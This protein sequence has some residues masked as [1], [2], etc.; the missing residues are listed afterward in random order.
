MP[1]PK[2]RGD[3]QSVAIHTVAPA[4]LNAKKCV[5]CALIVIGMEVRLTIEKRSLPLISWVRL[6]SALV[7]SPAALFGRTPPKPIDLPCKLQFFVFCYEAI[8]GCPQSLASPGSYILSRLSW[9]VQTPYQRVCSAQL[10]SS[11]YKR[12]STRIPRSVK[13]SAI[14]Y[15]L[16]N[17]R[18]LATL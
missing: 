9:Q 7:A 12:S 15:R 17:G 2:A 6:G 13:S 16:W 11:I 8:V 18:V 14:L 5:S 3:Q 4:I 10:F 1:Q